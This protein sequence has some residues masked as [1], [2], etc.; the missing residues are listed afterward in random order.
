MLTRAQAAAAASSDPAERARLADMI[1]RFVTPE[2]L[3]LMMLD[4]IGG[5]LAPAVAQTFWDFVPDD[6]MWPILLDTWGRLPE[7]ETRTIVL[8]ALRSRIADNMDLLRQA[9]A[10]TQTLRVRAAIEL[11]DGS[12][13]RLFAAELARLASHEDEVVRAQARARL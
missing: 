13:G 2:R 1:R 12:T 5:A 9:L 8:A 3:H 11:L 7:G 4:F 10:S 6:V